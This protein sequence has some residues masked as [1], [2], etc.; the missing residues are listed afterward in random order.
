[1]QFCVSYIKVAISVE[2]YSVQRPF[3]HVIGLAHTLR[4]L[5]MF[6]IATVGLP[7][8]SADFGGR[9]AWESPQPC[10]KNILYTWFVRVFPEQVHFKRLVNYCC[11]DYWF[12]QY[13]IYV[14]YPS[15]ATWKELVQIAQFLVTTNLEH[16]LY[17]NTYLKRNQCFQ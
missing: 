14:S 5:S 8:D 2:I 1:L 16:L 13:D 15:G 4:G 7:P 10:R 6:D 12:L 11:Q 3:Y 9:A 17:Q